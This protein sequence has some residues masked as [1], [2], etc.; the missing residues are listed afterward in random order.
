MSGKMAQPGFPVKSN[1]VYQWHNTGVGSC[2]FRPGMPIARL[3]HAKPFCERIRGKWKR[4]W[5]RPRRFE[6]GGASNF[7]DQAS[8]GIFGR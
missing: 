6:L 1:I 7:P 2:R 4:L 8:A 5:F 3:V